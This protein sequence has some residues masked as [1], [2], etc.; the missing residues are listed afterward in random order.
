MAYKRFYRKYGQRRQYS[1]Y[2]R[3]SYARSYAR[4]TKHAYAFKGFG[5][6]PGN[7]IVQN[8][9]YSELRNPYVVSVVPTESATYHHFYIRLNDCYDPYVT[10][11]A[12]TQAVAWDNLT[13][14]VFDR[15]KVWSGQCSISFTRRPVTTA[16]AAKDWYVCTFL[17]RSSADPTTLRTAMSQPGSVWQMLKGV[18]SADMGRQANV[19]KFNKTWDINQWF[20]KED[21]A[22]TAYNATP[23]NSIYMHFFI[24]KNDASAFAASEP[25]DVTAN[26]MQHTELTRR[27]SGQLPPS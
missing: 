3:K 18:D 24:T 4:Y 9:E 11:A 21:T 12:N 2:R 15:Y 25:M 20:Q 8:R 13:P 6:A 1:N 10:G 7:T 17:S 26:L 16:N 27:T 14:F 19:I 5:N 23:T 22:N